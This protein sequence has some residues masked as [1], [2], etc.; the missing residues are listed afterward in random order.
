MIISRETSDI[1]KLIDIVWSGWPTVWDSLYVVDSFDETG[2][3]HLLY[4]DQDEDDYLD[5]ENEE[6][7][8]R[9]EDDEELNEVMMWLI[10]GDRVE[11][12]KL[13]QHLEGLQKK[14]EEIEDN[15]Q[16]MEIWDEE[17][18]E[19]MY[20]EMFREEKMRDE[21]LREQMNQWDEEHQDFDHG[22]EDDND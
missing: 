8:D 15:E 4:E 11:D 21:M 12:E 20:K 13:R 16:D 6:G 18:N 2:Y 1:I 10:Y 7:Y 9:D 3:K 19:A 14:Y 22:N 17:T 5:E